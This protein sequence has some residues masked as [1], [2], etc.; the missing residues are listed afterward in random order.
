MYLCKLRAIFKNNPV[1]SFFF[2]FF[3]LILPTQGFD[4]VLIASKNNSSMAV[5]R[6][7]NYSLLFLKL[8]KFDFMSLV[9]KNDY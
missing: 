8:N 4:N 2:F 7:E 9:H 1:K 5:K 3:S 6:S